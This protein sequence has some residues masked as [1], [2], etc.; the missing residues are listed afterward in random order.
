MKKLLSF[1]IVIAVALSVLAMPAYSAET[2]STDE[3]NSQISAEV[4]SLEKKYGISITYPIT[5]NGYAGISLNNLSTLDMSFSNVTPSVIKQISAYYKTINGR[6]L[7]IE[8]AL[9]GTTVSKNGGVMLAAFEVDTSII[10]VLL[11]SRAGDAIISGENPIAIVH[12]LGHAFHLMVMDKYGKSDLESKWI[13]F[14]NGIA[15]D[16][17]ADFA[18]P[19]KRVFISGYAA[20]SYEEDFAD[21]FASVFVRN[22]AGQGFKT[23]LQKDG[24]TTGLGKKVNF[25]GE[26]IPK[27]FKDSDE[28]LD[29]YNRI[30][31]TATSMTF[32]DCKFSGEYLQYI[33]YPQPKNVLKGIQNGLKITSEQS[34]WIRKLGAW[35]VITDKGKE[36]FLFPGGTYFEK[37]SRD[38]NAA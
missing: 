13:K 23:Y 35:R 34:T 33:G 7:T 28:A 12:E 9:S 14:N 27:Y 1:A 37:G 6:Q 26:L 25:I 17:N 24:E 29:N 31:K 18:S 19:N 22:K 15:Y 8:Y 30:Y 5:S 32:E 10:L 38:L 11:P 21:T 2:L 20:T 4:K 3:Y 36:Y 16:P